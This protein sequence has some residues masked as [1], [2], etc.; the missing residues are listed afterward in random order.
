MAMTDGTPYRLRPQKEIQREQDCMR[1]VFE[2]A[3][4]VA[5]I[6]EAFGGIGITAEVWRDTHPKA[7]VESWELDEECVQT[8]NARNLPRAKAFVGDALVAARA[9][10]RKGRGELGVSLDY[11]RFTLGHLRGTQPMDQGWK[12]VLMRE[13]MSRRPLWIEITDS[14]AP[15]LHLNWD[16]YGLRRPDLDVYVRVWG[17]AFTDLFPGYAYRTHAGHHA[18]TYI[19]MVREDA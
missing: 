4:P 9:L 18:A 15:Y 3:P 10:P 7:R 1:R 2:R 12:I 14:A 19:L 16:G 6:F 5:R 13:V 11:N 17:R 8:Y